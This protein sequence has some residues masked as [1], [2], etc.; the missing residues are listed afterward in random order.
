MTPS[1]PSLA[2]KEMQR[3]PGHSRCFVLKSAAGHRWFLLLAAI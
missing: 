3:M 1:G 2:N